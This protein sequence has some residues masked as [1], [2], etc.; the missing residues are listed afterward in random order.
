MGPTTAVLLLIPFLLL[1]ATCLAAP[2]T[3]DQVLKA[4]REV[5]SPIRDKTMKVTMRVIAPGGGERVKTLQGYEKHDADA[6]KV[7]WIFETPLDLQGTGFLAWQNGTEAD[8]L[9]VYFPGQRRVRRVPPSIRREN[10]Q[11]SMFTYED[12]IA[13][14]FLDY[15]GTH[16]LEG[17]KPC[18]GGECF[19]VDSV[20][21][22][23]TFAYERLRTF[24]D[25]KTLLPVRVEFFRDGLLKV[26]RVKKTEDI[27]GIP[28][29]VLVEMESPS[30]GYLTR[31]ELQ[32]IDYNEDLADNMFTIEYLSQMG[33]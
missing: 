12:L 23:G 26:M 5:L 3:G 9:W 31:V 6:R 1:P 8:S 19:V 33:K 11:G 2:E 17:T 32:N 24:V 7:L 28:S 18:D 21:D 27:E 14:F 30:D 15:A 29:I 16:T 4:A 25:T 13:V 22:E 10:F 20:L